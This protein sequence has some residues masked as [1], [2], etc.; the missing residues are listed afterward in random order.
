MRFDLWVRLLSY[1]DEVE[2]KWMRNAMPDMPRFA[3]EWKTV[4]I[5][6][7]EFFNAMM[8]RLEDSYA[9]FTKRE[10]SGAP[11]PMVRGARDRVHALYNDVCAVFRDNDV[12]V[13]EEY[14]CKEDCDAFW[15]HVHEILDAFVLCECL[16][17][18]VTPLVEAC[19]RNA[20]EELLQELH[21][22]V[23]D[24]HHDY[25]AEDHGRLL[26][27]VM[28]SE[29]VSGD[30]CNAITLDKDDKQFMF[31]L[32][33]W[34]Q[35]RIPDEKQRASAV[36]RLAKAVKTAPCAR[37]YTVK[38]PLSESASASA[39]ASAGFQVLTLEKVAIRR[40]RFFPRTL[41][42]DE[43]QRCLDAVLSVKKRN[44]SYE[45]ASTVTSAASDEKYD[46]SQALHKFEREAANAAMTKAMTTN[47]EDDDEGD[48]DKEDEDDE[49]T[50][51]EDASSCQYVSSSS[52]T[53]KLVIQSHFRRPTMSNDGKD[54]SMSSDDER[55]YEKHKRDKPD[56]YTKGVCVVRNKDGSTQLEYENTDD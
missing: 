47:D 36:E 51:S 40:Q 15:K 44:D 2:R 9:L 53:R 10:M 24:M 37:E 21:E 23:S 45:T 30:D 16:Q 42:A 25:D 48:D 55:L 50:E 46:E 13:L 38:V 8:D 7:A 3:S 41:D 22:C 11:M 17:P 35:A 49:E 32:D 6:V 18:K 39:D 28:E 43:R 31:N 5:S 56:G 54:S 27:F 33:K 34:L 14:E 19:N 26:K 12:S 52:G 20:S 4:Q 1:R 29:A